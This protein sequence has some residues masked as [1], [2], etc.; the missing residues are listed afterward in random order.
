MKT[1]VKMIITLSVIGII[2]G[3]LLSQISSWAA[4]K[5]AKHRKEATEQAIYLVQPKAKDYEKVNNVDFELYRVF[6]AQKD[7]IGYALPYEGNGFQGK[8][9]LMLGVTKKLN[10]ISGLEILEQLETPGLGSKVSEEPFKKQFS[11]LNAEP[12]VDLVKGVPPSKANEIQ[13][14]TGATISS[15]SVVKIIN[16]GLAKLRS[17]RDGGKL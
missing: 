1:V 14:I 16:D 3:A 13:A 9:R 8:I 2:T 15:K 7:T 17:E 11:D 4:P 12:E 10:S 6:D 5:I